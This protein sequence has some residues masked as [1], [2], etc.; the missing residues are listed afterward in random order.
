[1]R[2]PIPPN[3]WQHAVNIPPLRWTPTGLR[4]IDVPPMQLV[5]RVERSSR[6]RRML[7]DVTLGIVLGAVTLGL[8]LLWKAY[9]P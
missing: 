9:S 8:A 1:M 7:L 2:R 4:R 3:Q 5:H 6:W